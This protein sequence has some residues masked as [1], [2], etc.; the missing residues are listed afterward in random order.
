M[1][2]TRLTQHLLV[3]LTL[4]PVLTSADVLALGNFSDGCEDFALAVPTSLQFTLETHGISPL[5]W[6][7]GT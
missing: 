4:S 6:L 3:P 5:D 2:V 1:S 7:N